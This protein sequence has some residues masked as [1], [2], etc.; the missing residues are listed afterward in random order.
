MGGGTFEMGS[1]GKGGIGP[2]LY[3]TN[4]EFVDIAYS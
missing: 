2:V 3:S 4:G 1:N